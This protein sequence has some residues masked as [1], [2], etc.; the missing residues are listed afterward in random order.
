LE[1]VFKAKDYIIEFNKLI[2]GQNEFDFELNTALVETLSG[3]TQSYPLTGNAHLVLQKGSNM[4]E[5]TFQLECKLKTACDCCLKEIDY[6]VSKETVLIIKLS[7]FERYDDDEII[8]VSPQTIQFDVSQLLYD[9]IILSLPIR[10]TCEEAGLICQMDN[11]SNENN[12][13]NEEMEENDPRW[14]KL[15]AFF[16]K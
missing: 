6:P 11:N 8:Y 4:Y 10:K 1:K 2:D 3:N 13:P 9:T 14:E 5:L 15:K 16:K 12:N 7:E